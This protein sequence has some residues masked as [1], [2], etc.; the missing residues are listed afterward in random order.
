MDLRAVG[1]LFGCRVARY[2]GLKARGS[3]WSPPTDLHTAGT[4]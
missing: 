1:T 4:S 3:D 2:A